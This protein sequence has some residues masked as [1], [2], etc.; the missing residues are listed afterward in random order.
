MKKFFVLYSLKQKLTP[1]LYKT[2]L[3]VS[4]HAST[5]QSLKFEEFDSEDQAKRFI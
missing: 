3:T 4:K 5:N 1:T 2:K